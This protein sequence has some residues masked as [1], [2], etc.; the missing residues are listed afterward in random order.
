MSA[1]SGFAN[2]WGPV[3]ALVIVLLAAL[4]WIVRELFRT[5]RHTLEERARSREVIKRLIV[6]V[7]KLSE[8]LEW[9]RE[10]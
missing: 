10:R 9:R 6:A 7:N 8:K 5:Q 2:D 1:I 4:A 3:W